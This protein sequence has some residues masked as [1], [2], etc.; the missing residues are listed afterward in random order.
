M[1][2][3]KRSVKIELNDIETFQEAREQVFDLRNEYAKIIFD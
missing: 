1:Q 3:I 2:E